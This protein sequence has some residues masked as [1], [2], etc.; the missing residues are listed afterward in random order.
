MI[1]SAVMPILLSVAF[2]LGC[3]REVLPDH[4]PA[5]VAVRSE[6]LGCLAVR[7]WDPA[8]ESSASNASRPR[9]MV[10]ELTERA[11][12]D[13][14]GRGSGDHVAHVRPA[15][16]SG[17]DEQMRTTWRADAATD[18][19]RLTWGGGFGAV[20]VVLAVPAS[21]PEVLHGRAVVWTDVAPMRGKNVAAA[22]RRMP[23]PPPP[24]SSVSA[25][26]TL[27]GGAT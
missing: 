20:L 15:S 21:L 10:I 18:S 8:E 11:I 13:S 25:R 9:P 5:R 7:L 1:R 24:D 27:L 3:N 22:A 16:E 26:T 6:L 4:P 14:A 19:V 17:V 23:C 2:G 12:I